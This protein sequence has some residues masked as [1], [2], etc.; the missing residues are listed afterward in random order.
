[1]EVFASRDVTRSPP[2]LT[3]QHA[4]VICQYLAALYNLDG[5]NTAE[6]WRCKMVRFRLRCRGGV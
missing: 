4:N 6:K 1:M 5:D 2:V 3:L